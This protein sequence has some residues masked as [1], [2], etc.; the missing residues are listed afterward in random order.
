MPPSGKYVLPGRRNV[1][2]MQSS[3]SGDSVLFDL[4]DGIQCQQ[5][6]RGHKSTPRF[7]MAQKESER[8]KRERERICLRRRC[9]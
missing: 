4:I 6:Y 9:D 7:T 5:R 3:S 8:E 2:R 1:R